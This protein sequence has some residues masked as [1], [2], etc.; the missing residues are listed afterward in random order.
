MGPFTPAI[1]GGQERQSDREQQSDQQ[2]AA[3]GFTGTSQDHF[4]VQFP[5]S[6]F[7]LGAFAD[8][9]ELFP[10]CGELISVFGR[11]GNFAATH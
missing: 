3:H 7:Q 9:C 11:T 5:D 4:P 8:L 6:L 1:A 10:C 2:K